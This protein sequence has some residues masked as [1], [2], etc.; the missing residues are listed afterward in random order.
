[1]KMTTVSRAALNLAALFGCVVAVSLVINLF[2]DKPGFGHGVAATLIG[3][4]LWAGLEQQ[5]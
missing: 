1:M 4:I 2:F 3:S 5:T